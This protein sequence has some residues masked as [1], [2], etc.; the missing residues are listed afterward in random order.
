MNHTSASL[1]EQEHDDTQYTTLPVTLGLPARVAA[2]TPDAARSAAEVELGRLA[3]ELGLPIRAQV[4]VIATTDDEFTVT[5]DGHQCRYPRYVLRT[6]YR[7]AAGWAVPLDGRDGP[8]W[9]AAG[10]SADPSEPQAVAWFGHWL[11]GAVGHRPELLL[12]DAV[13]DELQRQSRSRQRDG[14]PA[15]FRT[16]WL[17]GLCRELVSRHVRVRIDEM[18]GALAESGAADVSSTEEAVEWLMYRLR[19]PDLAVVLAPDVAA[20]VLPQLAT[21]EVDGITVLRQEFSRNHGVP[22]PFVTLTVDDTLPSGT[23]SGKINSIRTVPV[24]TLPPGNLLRSG[25]SDSVP[26]RRPVTNPFGGPPQGLEDAPAATALADATGWLLRCISAWLNHSVGCFIDTWTTNWALN[27]VADAYPR[28][29]R[30]ALSWTEYGGG[31]TGLTRLEYQ[32]IQQGVPGRDHV[33]LLEHIVD[34]LAGTIGP[35]V[36]AVTSARR[37]LWRDTVAYAVE[38]AAE[39]PIFQVPGD[40]EAPEDLILETILRQLR[41]RAGPTPDDGGRGPVLVCRGDAAAVATLVRQEFPTV[42]V[43]SLDD[44]PEEARS[45]VVTALGL[46]SPP[47]APGTAPK[48]PSGNL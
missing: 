2:V 36:E 24:P 13:L 27:Q 25:D 31:L 38:L 28:L 37:A 8:G 4:A 32:L 10:L 23:F 45:R 7:A 40:L 41:H 22:A 47:A 33:C 35:D 1:T 14:L 21:G 20:Q 11:R 42:L 30:T 29:V 12:T 3:A 18:H 9:L 26:L 43:L 48:S 34:R 46:P 5:I 16:S 44:V 6:A 15:A 39:V 19:P 17:P